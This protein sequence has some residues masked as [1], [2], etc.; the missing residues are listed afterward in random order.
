[1]TVF[2]AGLDL[3]QAGD[4]TALVVL[5]QSVQ[6][7]PETG[8]A[9]ASYAARHLQRW[10]LGT[11]YPNVVADVMAFMADPPLAPS[12]PIAV[13]GTGVGRPVVDLFRPLGKRLI[14]V[15]IHG[16]Q[17]TTRDPDTGYWQVPKREL[18]GVVQVLLQSRRLRI[19]PGLADAE[20][21]AQE[22]RAFRA[23]ISA[24][25]HDSYAAGTTPD[26]WRTGGAHDDLV[27]ALALACWYAERAPKPRP[28]ASAVGGSR[29][30]VNAY[31]Q[32][33]RS[34]TRADIPALEAEQR[35]RIAEQLRAGRAAGWRTP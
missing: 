10:P 33:S 7:S 2:C 18:V 11:S 8:K 14:P 28:F 17:Q 4:P 22:L 6:R 16:G 31:Q 26:D 32:V 35:V 12:A 24:S 25:G 34:A 5:E 21:L 15:T 30:V 20:V 9:V 1:M 13:D 29:P 19:A 27:L 23:R 3:G